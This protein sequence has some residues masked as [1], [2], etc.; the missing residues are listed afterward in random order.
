MARYL[1]LVAL[2]AGYINGAPLEPANSLIEPISFEHCGRQFHIGVWKLPSIIEADTFEFGLVE[3]SK[4]SFNYVIRGSAV[5]KTGDILD[6]SEF[7]T[8]VKEHVDSSTT[9]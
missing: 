4:T 7:E 2:F 8:F 3:E 6:S 5:M 9:C 1:L